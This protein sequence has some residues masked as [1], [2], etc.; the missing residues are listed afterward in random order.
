M[1]LLFL[2]SPGVG[3]G[4]Y[5]QVLT[6]VLEIPHISTG[7]LLREEAKRDTPLGREINEIMMKGELVPDHVMLKLIEERITHDD[8][9][10]GFI[11]DGFPRNLVQANHLQ[12]LVDITH[13]LNFKADDEVIIQRLSGRITCKKCNMIY[14]KVGK[15]PEIEGVCDKC[16]GELFQREDDKP[17]SVKKRLDVYREKT[18]PLID[19][20]TNKGLLVEVVINKHIIEIK[21]RLI[22]QI[23]AYLEGKINKIEE[24]K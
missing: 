19:H 1:I 7:D 2:G 6:E 24:I 22:S 14:N 3:K 20:Y 13:V 4:T 16:G 21:E 18:Q 11:L 10:N 8:C 5:A 17:E 12:N 23:K 9:K 15:K